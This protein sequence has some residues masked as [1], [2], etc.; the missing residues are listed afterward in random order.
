MQDKFI[1]KLLCPFCG[2]DIKVEDAKLADDN[3]ITYG[4][5]KCECGKHP[6]IGG[7]LYL[8]RT[9]RPWESRKLIN[10]LVSLIEHDRYSEALALAIIDSQVKHSSFHTRLQNILLSHR[11]SK[12][13]EVLNARRLT[14]QMALEHFDR[15]LRSPVF[16]GKPPA[17]GFFGWYFKHRFAIPSLWPTWAFLPFIQKHHSVLNL[18]SGHGHGS[19]IISKFATPALNVCVESFFLGLW[20]TKK[21]MSPKAECVCIDCEFPL[22]FRESMFDCIISCDAFHFV[23]SKA[24]LTDEINRVLS[25]G[26][27]IFLHNHNALN[28]KLYLTTPLGSPL[29]IHGYRKLFSSNFPIVNILSEASVINSL[30][31]DRNVELENLPND[32]KCPNIIIL[33]TTNSSNRTRHFKPQWPKDMGRLVLNPFYSFSKELASYKLELTVPEAIINEYPIYKEVM[34]KKI[35]LNPQNL[36][37]KSSSSITLR[38]LKK[39]RKLIKSF[40]LL[41]VPPRYQVT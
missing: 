17:S 2:S 22:P 12:V 41:S 26:S 5:V 37:I 33:A 24:A 1:E 39:T 34:P 16:I 4:T 40:I 32:H 38:D 29:T 7:I 31:N 18:M 6:I 21:F 3:D 8:K 23:N 30:I 25:D 14:Y 35:M 9:E 28:N 15:A 10:T 11:I 13:I 36:T 19:F 27:V 20:L